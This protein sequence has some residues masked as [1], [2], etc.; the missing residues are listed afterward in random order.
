[1]KPKPTRR[2]P[3]ALICIAALA[4]ATPTWAFNDTAR[5]EPDTALEAMK[6]CSM[7]GSNASI[8]VLR[9]SPNE[10]HPLQMAK[11]FLEECRD[12]SKDK[13]EPDWAE[14]ARLVKVNECAETRAYIKQRWGQP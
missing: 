7:A 8:C 9:H 6:V 13:V 1:V 4:M 3:A 11:L 10:G 14:R 5:Q 2:H 12:V